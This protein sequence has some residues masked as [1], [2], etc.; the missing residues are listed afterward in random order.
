M[1]AGSATTLS[2]LVLSVDMRAPDTDALLLLP[3]LE[4][5]R[6]DRRFRL[7]LVQK[8]VL[9]RETL[10]LLTAVTKA[11]EEPDDDFL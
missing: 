8:L 4:L 2:P 3:A 9:A 6:E 11:A 5:P 1:T 10:A 7:D